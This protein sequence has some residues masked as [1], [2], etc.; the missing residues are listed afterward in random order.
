MQV[1]RKDNSSES[2]ETLCQRCLVTKS[3][4]FFKAIRVGYYLIVYSVKLSLCSSMCT[5]QFVH[6]PLFMC[7]LIYASNVITD[8]L[9][10]DHPKSKSLGI[11]LSA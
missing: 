6:K 11:P 4:D 8:G 7:N 9:M 5:S 1:K 3:C 10:Y 2:L